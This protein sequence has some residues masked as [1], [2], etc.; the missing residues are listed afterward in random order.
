MDG[1]GVSLYRH[2]RGLPVTAPHDSSRGFPVPPPGAPPEFPPVFAPAVP[3]GMFFDIALELSPASARKLS[4]NEGSTGQR[5]KSSISQLRQ[6]EIPSMGPDQSH[7]D[8]EQILL[9]LLV[10]YRRLGREMESP[11]TKARTFQ[12]PIDDF[13]SVMEEFDRIM[14]EFNS[15]VARQSNDFW[16]DPTSFDDASSEKWAFDDQASYTTG[17]SSYQKS[18]GDANIVDTDGPVHL[19]QHPLPPGWEDCKVSYVDEP[20]RATS[21]TGWEDW[22]ASFDN[23]GRAAPPPGWEDRNARVHE[24]GN[25]WLEYASAR[26]EQPTIHDHGLPQTPRTPVQDWWPFDYPGTRA[27]PPP[28]VLVP[29]GSAGDALF[30]CVHAVLASRPPLRR[31]TLFTG[32]SRE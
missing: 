28:G 12:T 7:Q 8:Q 24:E 26:R 31:Q 2:R 11:G 21:L 10:E 5:T 15:L 4:A 1:Y 29:P 19:S 18:L 6:P 13:D 27:K 9:D 25:I 22:D 16:S 3:P 23:P 32:I 20:I 30:T 17:Y 14:N